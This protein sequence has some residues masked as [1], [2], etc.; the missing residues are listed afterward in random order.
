MALAC[1]YMLQLTSDSQKAGDF[2]LLLSL[3]AQ[4]VLINYCFECS[5][6]SFPCIPS[7]DLS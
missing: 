2:S 5:S 3:A 4:P 7:K 1:L 6:L